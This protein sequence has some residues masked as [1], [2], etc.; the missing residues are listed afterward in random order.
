MTHQEPESDDQRV[1]EERLEGAPPASSRPEAA[2]GDFEH[3]PESEAAQLDQRRQTAVEAPPAEPDAAVRDDESISG[4][5]SDKTPVAGAALLA[6]LADEVAALRD[7]PRDDGRVSELEHAA[8]AASQAVLWEAPEPVDNPERKS[9]AHAVTRSA[10]EPDAAESVDEHQFDADATMDIDA[11]ELDSH[12]EVSAAPVD[13]SAL[14]SL[15]DRVPATSAPRGPAGSR[16]PPPPPS[17]GPSAPPPPGAGP[18]SAPPPPST[19]T[20]NDLPSGSG[21]PPPPP[22]RG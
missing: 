2:T 15:V 20:I 19:G 3:P 9:G 8:F 1:S 17:R 6:S 16:V 5:V 21:R 7:E 11:F 4:A 18:R 10:S 14:S 13:L 22:R 12:D